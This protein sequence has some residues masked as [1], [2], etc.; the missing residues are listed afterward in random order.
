MLD[1]KQIQLIYLSSKWLIKQ[2][3]QLTMLTMHLAQELLMNVQCSGGS[4]SFAKETR[5]LKMRSL[6]DDHWKLT[7]TNWEQ[8]S[9]LILLKL[10]WEVAEELSVDHSTVISHLKQ[11]GE[12]KKP[13]KWML[14]ELTENQ[15]DCL[16]EMSSSLILR[17]SS[18]P[19]LDQMVTCNKKW[20]LYDSQQWPAQWLGQ[21]ETPKHFPK[22]N[23]YPKKVMVTVWWSAAHLIHYSSEP[24]RNHHIW[25]VCS[26]NQWDA[27][28]TATPVDHIDQ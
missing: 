9:V 22:P 25:E 16:F 24:W 3:R 8:S 18:E 7:V 27:P 6:V 14:H 4:R 5:T 19:F 23:L 15:K 20:I 26:A 1:Q 13:N 17:N 28:K 2:Q 21:E 11:I 12:V 10:T